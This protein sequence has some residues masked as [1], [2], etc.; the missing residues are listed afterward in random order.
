[1]SHEH[2]T[3]VPWN[4]RML[5]A[6]PH[7]GW[8]IKPVVALFLSFWSQAVLS[9]TWKF[10]ELHNLLRIR[11]STLNHDAEHFHPLAEFFNS[12]MYAVLFSLY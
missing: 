6:Y 4:D 10:T 5:F 8:T 11:A 2:S 1:M 9:G 3:A 7:R 12:T